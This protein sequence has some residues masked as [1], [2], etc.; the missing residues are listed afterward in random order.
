ME[1]VGKAIGT[2]DALDAVVVLWSGGAVER[3]CWLAPALALLAVAAVG[4]CAGTQPPALSL[5]LGGLVPK[6]SGPRPM[7]GRAL[8]LSP[9]A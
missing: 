8:W 9:T 5:S 3:W 2:K 1:G 4:P 7:G 6:A